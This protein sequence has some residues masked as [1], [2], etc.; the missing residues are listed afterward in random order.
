MLQFQFHRVVRPPRHPF[1]LRRLVAHPIPLLT[2]LLCVQPGCHVAT[3]A[4][5]M[6]LQLQDGMQWFH[7]DA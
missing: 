5:L 7:G 1:W 2:A 4:E 3:D 6:Q